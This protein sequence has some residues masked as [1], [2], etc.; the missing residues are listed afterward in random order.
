ML[1]VVSICTPVGCRR[2]P[3][4]GHQNILEKAAFVWCGLPKRTLPV[5]RW[6]YFTWSISPLGVSSP[7]KRGKILRC[8]PG[9]VLGVRCGSN[10]NG[11]ERKLVAILFADV[12]G[13]TA[14]GES[15]IQRM[16]ER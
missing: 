13:S 10:A 16:C 4:A 6:L 9:A 1:T 5:A 14:L 12:T 2:H 3:L 11:Q 15:L 8:V 7:T